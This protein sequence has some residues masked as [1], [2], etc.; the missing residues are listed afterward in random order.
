MAKAAK[1]GANK[2]SPKDGPSVTSEPNPQEG[3][4]EDDRA[5]LKALLETRRKKAAATRRAAN[6][7]DSTQEAKKPA[8]RPAKTKAPVA[9]AKQPKRDPAPGHDKAPRP[10]ADAAAHVRLL[11]LHTLILDRLGSN[12]ER[13]PTATPRSAATNADDRTSP[14]KV[15]NWAL[16][17]LPG[18]GKGYTL[19]D[20]GAGRGRVVLE[21]SRRSFDR[22]VGIE[23]DEKLFDLAMLNLSQWPRSIM[24]CRDVEI[25]H[26]D[27]LTWQLPRSDLVVYLFDPFDERSLLSFTRKLTRRIEEGHKVHVIKLGRE[28]RLALRDSSYFKLVS[29]TGATARKLR[30]LNPYPLEIYSSETGLPVPEQQPR[31]RKPRRRKPQ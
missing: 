31:R 12:P 25:I 13:T 20:V 26:A 27:A 23:N 21:A 10:Q 29:P 24:A 28:S 17:A 1:P 3:L 5:R 16:D 2:A 15:I 4:R 22:I 19:V 8:P 18:I 14:R 30:L 9:R 11:Q 7:A 6:K